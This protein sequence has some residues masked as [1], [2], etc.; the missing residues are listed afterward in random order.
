MSEW[1]TSIRVVRDVCVCVC[2]LDERTSADAQSLFLLDQTR[3]IKRLFPFG[4]L[5]FSLFAFALSLFRALSHADALA[6]PFFETSGTH[7]KAVGI[8]TSLEKGFEHIVEGERP[9]GTAAGEKR[10]GGG[11]SAPTPTR[12]ACQRTGVESS[13]S[14]PSLTEE[15]VSTAGGEV[16]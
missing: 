7:L 2:L 10:V 4:F 14:R 5:S 8:E 9:K 3:G 1:V 12:F 13:P 15:G 11:V 6:D 16:D